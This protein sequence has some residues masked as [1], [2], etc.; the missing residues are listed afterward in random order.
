MHRGE[1]ASRAGES[2]PS[3]RRVCVCVGVCVDVCGCVW[4][5]RERR[6]EEGSIEQAM[7]A[8]SE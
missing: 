8:I 5:G 1:R 4:V 3:G 6:A 2:A 7:K